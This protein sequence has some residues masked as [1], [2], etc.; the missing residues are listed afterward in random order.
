[1]SRQS[2][3]VQQWFDE[4]GVSHQNKTNKRIHWVM[5]PVIFFTI[6]GLLW[7]IPKADWMGTSTLINWATLAML[8]ALYFYYTLSVRIMLGMLVFTG[9]CL[10]TC[11]VLTLTLSIP[12][13]I[14]SAVLF[15]VAWVFQ[16][17]GHKIEGAKP[18]FFEDLQFLLVGPAW[19]L[20]FIYRR[21][22]INY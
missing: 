13:W 8:P 14:F 1:M 18:S 19:L 5:V 9:A 11:Y 4:Y 22:G 2:R 12:L 6:V 7:S 21:A 16:F 17:I 20:G 15:A 3:T 10:A